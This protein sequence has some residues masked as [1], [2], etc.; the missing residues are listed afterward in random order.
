MSTILHKLRLELYGDLA[1]S[2]F[3]AHRNFITTQIFTPDQAREWLLRSSGLSISSSNA[4]LA[5]ERGFEA[6][7]GST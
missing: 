5:I 1:V 7:R 6:A 2:A 4:K 3:L